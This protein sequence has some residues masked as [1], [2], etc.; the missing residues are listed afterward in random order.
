MAKAKKSKKTQAKQATQK[1]YFVEILVDATDQKDGY[2]VAYVWAP[3][4]RK[5]FD[6]LIEELVSE[7]VAADPSLQAPTLTAEFQKA[8]AT[9]SFASEVVKTLRQETKQLLT[10]PA[11]KLSPGAKKDLARIQAILEK[12][13]AVKSA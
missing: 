4:P 8:A 3:T 9:G 7:Q 6:I 10:G 12:Y 13:S 11:G 1:L 2:E 5:A